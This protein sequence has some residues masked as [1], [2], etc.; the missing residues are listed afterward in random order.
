VPHGKVHPSTSE[1]GSALIVA[2]LSTA[3]IM[4][5]IF[6]ALMNVQSKSH[7][8]SKARLILARDGVFQNV[9]RYSRSRSILFQ[10]MGYVNATTNDV[11]PIGAEHYYVTGTYTPGTPPMPAPNKID[12][13]GTWTPTNIVDFAA[14]YNGHAEVAPSTLTTH[15]NYLLILC[16]I[17]DDPVVT[18]AS[19]DCLGAT[20][21][22]ASV[23]STATPSNPLT[24]VDIDGKTPLT[25]GSGPTQTF[26]D[27]HGELCR[28][29][30]PTAQCPFGVTTRF[31]PHCPPALPTSPMCGQ[32][33]WMMVA[34]TV[35]PNPLAV[36]NYPDLAFLA[37]QTEYVQVNL[38]DAT[39]SQI[40]IVPN[41]WPYCAWY[42]SDQRPGCTR[43]DD[44]GAL[45]GG[46]V[47]GAGNCG[48]GQIPT[49][50]GA[51]VTVQW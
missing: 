34:I 37:A 32:A 29:P 36:P 9:R 49:A 18:P 44:G 45:G 6:A 11:R 28:A 14:T 47:S 31:V 15:P 21:P 7:R 23:P 13:G 42:P 24:L 41:I 25:T 40:P 30:T 33:Q 51:C 50:S 17:N 20:G 43:Q 22:S 46:T 5:T 12:I 27:A 1:K 10:S 3:V 39:W 16:L 8:A 2:V 35:T 4:G 48:A 19:A 26:Y 38:T